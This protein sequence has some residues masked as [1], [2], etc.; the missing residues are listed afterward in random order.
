MSNS[1]NQSALPT[2]QN[3]LIVPVG[4]TFQI[5]DATPTTTIK[6]GDAIADGADI[7]LIIPAGAWELMISNSDLHFEIGSADYLIL[8]GYPYPVAGMSGETLTIANDTGV[9]VDLSF[10]FIMGK[11]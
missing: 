3:N 9:S 10:A 5:E 2:D 7:D 8:A 4:S 1:Q 11:V 6:S